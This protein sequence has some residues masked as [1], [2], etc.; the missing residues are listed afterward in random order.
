MRVL[1]LEAAPEPGEPAS[2][3][4]TV[5]AAL[6]ADPGA[7]LAVLPELF[8]TGYD[9][10]AAHERAI[11]S[12]HEALELVRDAAG[13]AGA[14]VVVGFAERMPGGALANS[15]AC[16]DGRGGWAGLYRKTHLFGRER[17]VFTAGD[18]LLVV[19]LGGRR[20]GILNCFD[21]EFPEPARALARAGAELLVTVA[22]NMEPYGPDHALAVRARAL[23]NRLPHVYVNRTGSEGRARFVGE[24]LVAAPDGT[25]LLQLGS[26]AEAAVFDVELGTRPPAAV[27][28]LRHA[29]PDLPVELVTTHVQGATR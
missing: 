25:P 7:D 8:L 5:R 21:V 9:P 6:A 26:G 28:Y 19:E 27:D 23:D 3:A 2:N 16:I 10:P 15:V 12:D 17:E 29:R 24:S 14:A 11:G 18:R 22:A 1:L 13:E 20:V 4:E